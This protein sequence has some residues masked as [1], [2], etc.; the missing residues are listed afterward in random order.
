MDHLVDLI[1]QFLDLYN[2]IFT[3][4]KV[5]IYGDGEQKIFHF[6]S[7]I[8]SL[9]KLLNIIIW[10]LTLALW[11]MVTQWNYSYYWKTNKKALKIERA[12]KDV[13]IVLPVL[14]YQISTKNGNLLG[15]EEGISNTVNWYKKYKQLKRN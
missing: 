6:I 13:D 14:N 15:V 10:T 8:V 11:N 7:D 9:N 12:M 4:Q 3:N 5:I 2:S 1:C